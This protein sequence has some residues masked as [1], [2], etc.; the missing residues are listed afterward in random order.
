M[1]WDFAVY[2]KVVFPRNGIDKWLALPLAPE[3]HTPALWPFAEPLETPMSVQDSLCEWSPRQLHVTENKQTVRFR[4]YMSRDTMGELGNQLVS[5]FR[6][7]SDVGGRGTLYLI[8]VA[9]T[10]AYKISVTKENSSF[11]KLDEDLEYTPEVAEVLGYPFDKASNTWRTR[12]R[13]NPKKR[14]ASKKK[15]KK[16]KKRSA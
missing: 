7:A 1:S 2:G 16:K 10:I 5:V 11:E 6:A 8:G 12:S 9:N 3:R 14:A 4:G 15:K 13:A